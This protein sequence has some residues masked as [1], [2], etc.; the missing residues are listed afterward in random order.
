MTP[1]LVMLLEPYKNHNLFWESL[2]RFEQLDPQLS[3]LKVQTYQ[4]QSDLVDAMPLQTPGVYIL[5]GG[6]QVGKTTLL[7]Q[8]ILKSLKKKFWPQNRILYL[9]CDTIQT[10]Q[11]FTATLEEF[12][13][14]LDPQKPFGLF[15]DEVT[16][17]EGWDRAIKFFADQGFFR[18]GTL[19]LTGSDSMI[20][21]E[22]MMRFPGRRGIAPQTDFHLYPLS[23]CEFVS[24][25]NPKIVQKVQSGRAGFQK[26]IFSILENEEVLSMTPKN[27]DDLFSFWETYLLTGGFITAINAYE[28]HQVI[29]PF[30]YQT[31]FQWILGDFLKRGKR[32]D[33]L[34]S[35][36]GAL[37][38]KIG[39]QL[40]LHSLLNDVVVDHHQTIQD[41]IYLMERMD[42]VKIL[43]ALQENKLHTSTL[44]A[45]KKAR[46]MHPADPLIF[47]TLRGWAHQESDFYLASQ[48]FLKTPKAGFLVEAILANLASRR[49]PVYYIKA[50]GEIDLAV[51]Q[52]KMFLPIE[53]K[54]SLS[55]SRSD[56]K[57]I[58]KYKKGI[59]STLS[60]E[61]GHYE[62]L[63]MIPI[64]IL[65]ILF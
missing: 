60:R 24:L 41:Y 2:D 26:D 46:K 11:Q 25:K 21:K 55:P 37:V 39:S 52:G 9:P 4:Y 57:Q 54:N 7:K 22:A 35:I 6:R 27:L 10:C 63:K 36:V 45:P 61:Q 56:L 31:Y 30:V 14:T 16:Y 53:I 23:F 15:I 51:I 43:Q 65:A 18:R 38:D 47:H 5:T 33:Y 12:F 29:P 49:W 1:L 50:E 44:G 34:K 8:V 62:H 20:L 3:Q 59:L 48:N 13:K 42:I 28:R 32:E 40:T 64:P 58:L 17:V 19:V